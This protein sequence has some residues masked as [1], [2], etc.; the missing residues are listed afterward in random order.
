MNEEKLKEIIKELAK[1]KKFEVGFVDARRIINDGL[2]LIG[3]NATD[4]LG[5]VKEANE[6][7]VR[8][9]KGAHSWFKKM[10]EDGWRFAGAFEY[11]GLL[12]NGFII[13]ER[14]IPNKRLQELIESLSDEKVVRTGSAMELDRGP[15]LPKI[16][17]KEEYVKF[18]GGKDPRFAEINPDKLQTFIPIE[19]EKDLVRVAPGV[20]QKREDFEKEVEK[21]R[22]PKEGFESDISDFIGDAQ[23]EM[24]SLEEIFFDK[25]GKNA[26]WRGKE[27]KAFKDWKR[28]LENE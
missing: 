14:E 4:I 3:M 7:R 24:K 13:M 1:P 25:T 9:V 20:Y 28:G 16:L 8:R 5:F 10:Y 6:T 22:E 17:S 19:K 26:I 12:Y 23:K 18:H 11:E 2:A 27:T 15:E 21:V